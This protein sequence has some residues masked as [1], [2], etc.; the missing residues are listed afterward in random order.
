VTKTGA[1]FKRHKSRQDLATPREFIEAVE[2]RFG[3]IAYD[4]AA[5]ETNHVVPAWFG[6]GSPLGEDTF[7]INWKDLPGNLW[8]NP[9]FERIPR[10]VLKMALE[11][12]NRPA[13]TF[14]LTPSSDDANWFRYAEKHGY[15]NTLEDRITFVGQTKK[16][17]KG[18]SLI[19]FGFGLVGRGR[20]HWDPTVTKAYER[21]AGAKATRKPKAGKPPLTGIDQYTAKSARKSKA[22]TN[23]A[24]AAE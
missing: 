2:R 13:W 19:I 24:E 17:P 6:P 3:P 22:K 9:E 1:G 10:Y 23:I 5:N 16:Y 7:R 14:L 20:W 12:Q 11:C 8:C 4:L 21:V 18:L 15:V